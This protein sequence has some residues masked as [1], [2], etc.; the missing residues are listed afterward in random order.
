MEEEE[1]EGRQNLFV[2]FIRWKRYVNAHWQ[3]GVHVSES[4]SPNQWPF[5]TF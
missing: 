5:L 2:H 3:A 1:A 4:L